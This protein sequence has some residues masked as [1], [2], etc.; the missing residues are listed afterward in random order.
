MPNPF[1][2]A[3]LSVLEA[4]APCN[5]L[6]AC[7]TI[8]MTHLVRMQ[9]DVA[10]GKQLSRESFATDMRSIAI[11]LERHASQVDE[12]ARSA[13]QALRELARRVET[14]DELARI[15][16]EIP[17]SPPKRRRPAPPLAESN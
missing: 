15:D 14:G 8:V 4:R 5:R 9:D 6:E 17:W 1:N 2:R 10:G 16:V 7:L 3:Q 11:E 12:A 13:V